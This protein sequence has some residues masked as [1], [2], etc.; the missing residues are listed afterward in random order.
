V[1]S[2]GVE[3]IGRPDL[4]RRERHDEVA[5][6]DPGDVADDLAAAQGEAGEL[7]ET[8]SM[9][10]SLPPSEGAEDTFVPVRLRSQVTELGLL[11][12]W[13]LAATGEGRWKMDLRVREDAE[14]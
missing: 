6:V 2:V 13:C 3:G 10:A 1:S 4:V 5:G 14:R 9:E 7:V 8:D 12:L 11:E